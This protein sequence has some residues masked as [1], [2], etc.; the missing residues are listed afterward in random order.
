MV[1]MTKDLISESNWPYRGPAVWRQGEVLDMY[2]VGRAELESS[3][4]G[5]GS[6]QQGYTQT[7]CLAVVEAVEY[8]LPT[9]SHASIGDKTRAIYMYMP[10]PFLCSKNK[11]FV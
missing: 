8:C 4:N 3:Y 2:I 9:I 11:L 7:A 5:I 10:C 1:Q 6:R